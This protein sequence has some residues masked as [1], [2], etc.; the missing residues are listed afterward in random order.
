MPADIEPPILVETIQN[1]NIVKFGG[2]YIGAPHALGPLDLQ[3]V[4]L[5]SIPSLLVAR[6][7]EET[8]RLVDDSLKSS[9]GDPVRRPVF[10]GQCPSFSTSDLMALS[11]LI[12]GVK[13]PGCRMAEI[14]SWL[15]NGSTQVFL[16]ELCDC[17]SSRLLCVDTWQGSPNVQR[18]RD[19]VAQHDVFGTFQMNVARA[20]SPV[21]V[22]ALL[23]TSIEAASIIADGILDLVF[24][25]ADH[26]YQSV[27][28]DIAAWRS[29][30]R[31][32]GVL[33]GHDCETRVTPGNRE[34]FEANRDADAI[35]GDG[36]RFLA[37]HPGCILAVHEAFGEAATLYAENPFMLPDGTEGLSTIWFVRT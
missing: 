31:P 18:H 6:T 36:T 10:T 3:H 22:Q 17:P 26:S 4:D 2:F 21:S 34:T 9:Y 16:T 11:R 29:K 25:D 5:R 20:Q 30:I 27:A 33:C 24:I 32:G 12:R 1:F 35:P 8:R 15:G 7:L 28:A 19:I 14:G 13:R 37:I 23:S